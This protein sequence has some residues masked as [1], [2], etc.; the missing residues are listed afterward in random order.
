ML[1]LY[2]TNKRLCVEWEIKF[3]KYIKYMCEKKW[4]KECVLTKNY[5][6][7]LATYADQFEI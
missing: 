7:E 6:G 1:I 3:E 5:R 2:D 4:A